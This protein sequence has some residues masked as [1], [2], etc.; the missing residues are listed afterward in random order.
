[1]KRV[2]E[3]IKVLDWGRFIA[4]P[5]CGMILADMGAEVIRVERSGGEEDR[6]IGLLGPN[7]QNM[8]Y[9]NYARN[10]KAITLNLMG[11][12]HASEVLADLVKEAD[13]II[14]NF[15]P[16]ARRIMGLT[17]EDMKAIKPD[18]I[19]TAISCYGSE[20]PYSQRTGFDYI[21]QIVS[22]SLGIG[23]YPDKPPLRAMMSW[24]DYGTALCAT[25]GTLL[26]LR[27]RD[28]TGEG[29]MVDLAL[30]R[31]A[32]SFMGPF[33]A[34][35][36][37]LERLRPNLG[38]R[39]AYVGPTDLFKCKDGYV[40]IATLMNTLWK[41][42]AKAI[43]HEELLDDPDLYND[44][45]R[46]E[47]RERIDPKIAEF[48]AQRTVDEVLAVMEEARIPC[49]RYLGPDEVS[50]D[51]HIESQNMVEYTDLEVPG[52]ERVPVCGIPIRLS[53]TPGRVERRAPRVGEHN[54]EI[55][56]DLL[57]YS[58]EKIAELKEQGVI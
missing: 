46:F 31:T 28:A 14:Q 25:V 34:E 54:E 26:A 39:A 21:A 35:A 24:V 2:L 11:N 57:G 48:T 5:Y 7:G 32:T 19:Y 37:V 16:G 45:A 49:G 3:D 43:G 18:I 50:R 30:L 56:G 53:K 55:Y 23:G 27:H 33:I 8:S 29:Q 20:G 58:K 12:K 36:E 51:P 22:G 9:P 10:K 47:H 42:L 40:F 38:N 6:T 17:Y 41:R 15:S 1:M 4:C 44:Y 13:V 52:L